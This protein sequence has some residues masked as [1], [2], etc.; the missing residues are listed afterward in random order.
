MGMIQRSA[1]P[2]LVRC[3][4]DPGGL[5]AG[6]FDAAAYAGLRIVRQIELVHSTA[7]APKRRPRGRQSPKRDPFS[8]PVGIPV[9]WAYAQPD[10][11]AGRR[12]WDLSQINDTL[13]SG[14]TER[15]PPITH[16]ITVDEVGGG[17][18]RS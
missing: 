3:F 8:A 18:C 14:G 15:R 6:E 17:Q 10:R 12:V 9:R 7:I 11:Y 5:I 4:A 2:V 13:S 1:F 16:S